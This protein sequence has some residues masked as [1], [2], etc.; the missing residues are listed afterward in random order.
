MGRVL[1]PQ[2]ASEFNKVGSTVV[3][4]DYIRDGETKATAQLHV[5]ILPANLTGTLDG[6]ENTGDVSL[7]RGEN[8][9]LECDLLPTGSAKQLDGYWKASVNGE[10]T[11]IVSLNSTTG[12]AVVSPPS[13]SSTYNQSG[14]VQVVCEFYSKDDQPLFKFDRNVTVFGEC[15]L[16][17]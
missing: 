8:K 13:G 10:E 1:P 16:S 5:H 12:R 15:S 11:R 7:L 9:T 4:C 17:Q 6:S 14:K 2:T 3:R